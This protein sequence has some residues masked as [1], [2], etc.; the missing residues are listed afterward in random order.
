MSKNKIQEERMKRYFIEAAKEI[1]RGEGLECANVRNISERAG[2]SYATLYNYFDDLKDLIFECVQDF[3]DE[4]MEFVNNSV[5][6]Y[7]DGIEKIKETAKAYINYFVQYPGIFDL[8]YIVKVT[9]MGL[10]TDT[11]QI[12]FTLLDD[13]CTNQWK[14]CVKANLIAKDQ[15]YKLQEILKYNITGLLLFY[16]SRKNPDNYSDFMKLSENNIN[17]ILRLQ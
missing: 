8:F 14:Y 4:C 1:L 3:R 7:S 17:S 13:L 15:S 6:N 2:Y 12:I 5:K 10:K 9:G 16:I 11:V